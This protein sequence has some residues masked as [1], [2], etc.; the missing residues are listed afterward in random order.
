M[1]FPGPYDT[2]SYVSVTPDPPLWPT[3]SEEAV[4]TPQGLSAHQEAQDNN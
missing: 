2:E 4:R 3:G 1:F